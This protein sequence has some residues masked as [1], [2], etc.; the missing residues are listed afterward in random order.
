GFCPAFVLV[1][2]GALKRP[3]G[4]DLSLEALRQMAPLPATT[5][6]RVNLVIAGVGGTGVVTVSAL[7]GTAAHLDGLAVS[8]LDMTGLAQKGG[9]VFSHVRIAGS[10][11]AL[12]GT[13]IAAGEADMLLACDLISGASRDALV[14]TDPTRTEAVVN[15][16][17]VPTA[18]FVLHQDADHHGQERI[19]RIESLTRNAR[20]IDAAAL[21]KAV[22]GSTAALN[23]FLL[24]YA[25]QQGAIPVSVEALEHAM[26][27]NGTAVADNHRAFHF[28][29][30]AAASPTT[31]EELVAGNRT[32]HIQGGSRQMLAA[33]VEAG[34]MDSG[35]GGRASDD[36]ETLIASRRALLTAY[37]N[38]SYAERFE[39]LVRRVQMAEAK[40]EGDDASLTR[41]VAVSYARLLA[42]KDEYEVA[43]LYSD[44]R[45]ETRLEQT[46]EGDYRKSYLLAPPLLGEKKRS[47]GPWIESGY[48]WLARL[49]FLRGSFFD[50]FGRFEERK[51]ERWSIEHF[52]SVVAELI[53]GL[54]G[55]NHGI[56]RSIA[57]LPDS[58]RGY[59]HVKAGKRQAW[60]QEEARLLI[61]FH[62]PP[63]PVLLFDPARQSAA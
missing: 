24:G 23:V 21:C 32:A 6:S 14:L 39:N 13:R 34:P 48:R 12:H 54:D 53:D 50:P 19:A 9:A 47:F 49:K 7:L 45:F 37:Q 4:V 58:V 55:S 61:E 17:V 5:D 27:L 28:G 43:R 25:W 31:F 56:A 30:L 51:L 41:A 57:A 59:G 60:L 63:A 62:R 18:E 52:E 8:T 15:T 26:E 2:G 11:G 42:Y 40:L 20:A 36:L 46:F 3:T 22:L 38:R 29:R 1:R 44:G 33:A 35:P 16:D 10:A